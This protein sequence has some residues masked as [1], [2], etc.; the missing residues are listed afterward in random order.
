M[1]RRSPELALRK[2]AALL[3]AAIL[4]RP[5]QQGAEGSFWPAASNTLRPSVQQSA[6]NFIPPTPVEV[7]KQ[8]RHLQ[9]PLPDGPTGRAI[10]DRFE[11][12]C[13]LDAFTA[14]GFF[15]FGQFHELVTRTR[16]LVESLSLNL[17]SGPWYSSP[18]AQLWRT[19]PSLWPQLNGLCETSEP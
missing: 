5:Q 1:N 19:Q 11:Q 7:W 18:W 10:A 4:G 17:D 12:C 13:P 9:R 6:R 16:F 3:Q 14:F 2:Q 8:V 15:A